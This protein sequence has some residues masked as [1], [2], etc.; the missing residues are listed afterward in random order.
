MYNIKDPRLTGLHAR[1]AI[2]TA[3]MVRDDRVTE[4]LM[5]RTFLVQHAVEAVEE[6][7][8]QLPMDWVRRVTVPLFARVLVPRLW[9]LRCVD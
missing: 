5:R 4:Y 7:F 2:L 8:N 6:R 9:V 3:M 1:E